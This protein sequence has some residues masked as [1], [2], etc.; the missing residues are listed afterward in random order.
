MINLPENPRNLAETV[1]TRYAV[2]QHI[3]VD[4][5]LL[6]LERFKQFTQDLGAKKVHVEYPIEYR[7]PNQQIASGWIDVLIETD[8]GYII[9]DHKSNPM[10]QAEWEKNALKYSGQLALYKSAV[11]AITNKPVIGCWVHFAVTGGCLKV[12]V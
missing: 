5:A 8:A 12:E 4:D 11:E 7:L 2:T 10:S 1:L 9:V 3:S 6:C